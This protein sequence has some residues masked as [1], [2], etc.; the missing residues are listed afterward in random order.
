MRAEEWVKSRPIACRYI[1]RLN[2]SPTRH[3]VWTETGGKGRVFLVKVQL[4]NIFRVLNT[5]LY[6]RFSYNACKRL[7]SSV[8]NTLLHFLLKHSFKFVQMNPGLRLFHH[9]AYL[10]TSAL[11]YLFCLFFF[12]LLHIISHQR[13]IMEQA[14]CRQYIYMNTIHYDIWLIRRIGHFSHQSCLGG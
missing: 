10:P 5:F 9:A 3:F 6:K 1:W 14:L 4:H 2:V 12:F 7:K 8:T 13:I 11:V